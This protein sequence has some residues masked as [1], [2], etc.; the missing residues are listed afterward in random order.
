ME[1]SKMQFL[2]ALL[3]GSL[4]GDDPS[5]PGVPLRLATFNIHHAE[6]IDGTLDLKRV[7]QVVREADVIAFQEVDVRF[8]ARSQFVDQ[9]VELAKTLEKQVAFG[10]NL[11]HEQGAY[12]VAARE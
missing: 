9:A 5:K 10:G 8:A 1:R 6:G 4:I 3:M 2:L 11:I 12:G 7:A